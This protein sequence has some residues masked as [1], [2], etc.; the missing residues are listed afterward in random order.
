MTFDKLVLTAAEECPD[1]TYSLTFTALTSYQ[2]SFT[3]YSTKKMPFDAWAGRV[4]KCDIEYQQRKKY[5]ED[6][7]EG[8]LVFTGTLYSFTATSKNKVNFTFLDMTEGEDGP[9]VVNTLVC[10]LDTTDIERLIVGRE[11]RIALEPIN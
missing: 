3:F 2:E 5:P 8:A 4:F 11:F 9:M 1:Q 7:I 6:E 10:D